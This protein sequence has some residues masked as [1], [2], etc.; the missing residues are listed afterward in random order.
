MEPLAGNCSWQAEPFWN[1][2]D[3]KWA[4]IKGC[5]LLLRI[6][7]SL[8]NAGRANGQ[9]WPDWLSWPLRDFQIC[10]KWVQGRPNFSVARI[11]YDF[12]SC[13]CFILFKTPSQTSIILTSMFCLYR[14]C[15]LDFSMLLSLHLPHSE[16]TPNSCRSKPLRERER[17][18]HR[19]P[20]RIG[21]HIWIFS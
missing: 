5:S 21:V 14:W 15:C 4:A 17:A 18:H 3:V 10:E 6:F 11:K 12:H 2:Q 9:L 7:F 13:C 8:L 1:G 16:L 19:V 20:E